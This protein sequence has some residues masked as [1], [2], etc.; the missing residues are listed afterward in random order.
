MEKTT[1]ILILPLVMTFFFI[2]TYS[3]NNEIIV[4]IS[5]QRLY[6]YNND[7]LVQSFPVSTSKY[8]EGQIEN[9][10]KTPL[11]LHEIKEKIGDNVPINTIFTAR[12]N[13]NKVAEIQIN[14]NDTEDDF[15]TSRILWLDGLENGINRGV[16]VDSY[17]RYIYIHGTHEEGL[18]GQK[19]SHGCIR[20]FN[21]DVIE[22][23]DMVSEGTKVQI[24]A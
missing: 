12:V 1:K 6:L 19:A 2:E 23:F 4:D 5:E 18:I 8:G 3:Q 17:G 13:T 20:M 14:P 11:G 21:N 10:F 7:N 9:S 24:R 15:V 22:L 16:G